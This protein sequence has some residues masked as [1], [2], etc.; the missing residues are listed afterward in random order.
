[1]LGTEAAPRYGAAS[2]QI[3]PTRER[4]KRNSRKGAK[5]PTMYT[6]EPAARK[7][8]T[9]EVTSCFARARRALPS[10]RARG[11]ATDTADRGRARVAHFR[12]KGERKFSIMTFEAGMC[13]KTKERK[14]ECPKINRNFDRNFRCFRLTDGLFAA[15]CCFTTTFGRHSAASEAFWRLASRDSSCHP[16][17]SREI[18]QR[19]RRVYVTSG[20]AQ[21]NPRVVKIPR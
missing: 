3:L 11:V 10:V 16:G 4:R 20:S 13:M 15:K 5:S 17:K 12:A 1:M 7:R 9:G 14:T 19:F 18:S 6:S 8:R 2:P 21:A